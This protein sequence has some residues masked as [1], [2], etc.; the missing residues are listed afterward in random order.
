MLAMLAPEGPVGRRFRGP[1]VPERPKVP[2]AE[3]SGTAE[4]PSARDLR[5]PF[6]DSWHRVP[7]ALPGTTRHPA[8]MTRQDPPDAPKLRT[9]ARARYRRGRVH[10]LPSH[11]RPTYPW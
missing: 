8:A 5:P 3:G 6:G 4:G 11:R 7:A 10:R 2:G 9:H 1:K